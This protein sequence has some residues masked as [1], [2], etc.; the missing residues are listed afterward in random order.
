VTSCYAAGTVGG[1]YFVGGLVGS[2][3]SGSVTSCYAGGSISGNEIIGG[4][5]GENLGSVTSCYATCTVS[6]SISA[7]GLVG[8]N[9]GSVSFCYATGAVSG[10]YDIGGLLG[11]SEAS[12]SVTSCY[13]TGAV[14]GDSYVGGLVGINFDCN[15]MYCYSAGAVS[16]NDYVG[17]LV[18]DGD[19]NYVN[20]SFWDVNT[21]G[22]STSD[23]GTGKTTAE[24]MTEST[25]TDAGWGFVEVWGIGENQTYPFL[26]VHSAGDL[27]HDGIVDWRDFAIL[28][29]HWLD[30]TGG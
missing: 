25:F 20:A 7:G 8:D 3:D 14:S 15:I 21:S 17:G 16:G 26:R 9:S 19:V 22:Q 30:G 5:V 24:M 12:G 11:D 27:N 29:G 13:A 23:G 28:A 4:L 1:V 2:N 18:G 6:C 10:E